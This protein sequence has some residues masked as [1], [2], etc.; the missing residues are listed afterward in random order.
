MATETRNAGRKAHPAAVLAA[1]LAAVFLLAACG[2]DGDEVDPGN[3]EDAPDYTAM[4]KA[5]PPELAAVYD[6]E[7][8][9]LIAT[10]L[11]AYEEQLAQFE[12]HPAVVN[13]WASWC[14]PCR[15]EFP[16]FQDTAAR[17]GDE[18]AFLGI[19]VDD[20]DDAA[21]T[22]LSTHPIPYGSV[23]DPDKEIVNKLGLGSFL[24]ATIFYNAEGEKTYTHTGPYE[25]AADLEADI[26]RYAVNG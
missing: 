3:A 12:G 10:G 7:G 17:R 9:G 6:A 18:V 14:G 16:H 15:L 8:A 5:A 4:V 25:S 13:A 21:T 24:P 22:F 2:S 23:S 11:E 19:D 1:L 26:D 20:S